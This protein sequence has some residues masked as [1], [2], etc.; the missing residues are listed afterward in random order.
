VLLCSHETGRRV[1]LAAAAG[2]ARLP[3]RF[4]QVG[5]QDRSQLIQGHARASW[6][7][8]PHGIPITVR[9][10]EIAAQDTSPNSVIYSFW[11]TKEVLDEH[12]EKRT[13][14]RLA[15]VKPMNRSK[16]CP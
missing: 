10:A 9:P 14:A 12:D 13:S 7:H 4:T 1:T 5:A 15:S 16:S 11:W 8:D 2:R 3:G 6:I